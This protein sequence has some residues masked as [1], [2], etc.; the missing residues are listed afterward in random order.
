VEFDAAGLAS[1]RFR[2]QPVG[3][4]GTARGTFEKLRVAL[5]E[6]APRANQ[7]LVEVDWLDVGTGPNRSAA[8]AALYLDV[9]AITVRLRK[10][11]VESTDSSIWLGL[12]P[13]QRTEVAYRA[14]FLGGSQKEMAVDSLTLDLLEETLACGHEGALFWLELFGPWGFEQEST[15]CRPPHRYIRPLDW[16]AA[17][18]IPS[19]WWC[20]ALLIARCRW[21]FRALCSSGHEEGLLHGEFKASSDPTSLSF[22][23]VLGID[24]IDRMTL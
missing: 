24:D 13:E 21:L 10:A 14:V 5:G 12:D 8:L 1:G 16:P 11:T 6:E 2:F 3:R 9:P 19:H 23:P 15:Q 20:E 18:L 17:L 22:E 7:P 4:Q